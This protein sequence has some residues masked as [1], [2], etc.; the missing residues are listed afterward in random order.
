MNETQE[1]ITEILIGR[2]ETFR[3]NGADY[4][5]YPETLGSSVIISCMLEN[6][7]LDGELL[8]LNPAL[9]AMR[10][11]EVHRDQVCD[12]IATATLAG[13]DCLSKSLMRERAGDFAGLGREDLAELLLLVLN[14]SKW[15]RLSELLGLTEEQ[16]ETARIA[17]LRAGSSGARHYGGRSIFGTLLDQACSRY[18]WSDSYVIWEISLDRLRMML[19]D[20]V[21]TVY[22]SEDERMKL[23]IYGREEM[24]DGDTADIEEL[25]ALTKG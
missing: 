19:C 13:R 15:G 21:S 4:H 17:R 7:D 1:L 8:A 20:S 9:E 25:R 11:A 10:Q 22:L 3:L 24:L 23:N 12:I 5:I 14:R 6:L 2:P 16:E 18:G